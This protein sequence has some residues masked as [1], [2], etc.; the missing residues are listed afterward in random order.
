MRGQKFKVR[1]QGSKVGGNLGEAHGSTVGSGA[2]LTGVRVPIAAR[3]GWAP[4][5]L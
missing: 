1:F 3:G 4:R 5:G 2:I